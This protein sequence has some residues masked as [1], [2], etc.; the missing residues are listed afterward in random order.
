[1]VDRSMRRNMGKNNDVENVYED[2]LNFML[3]TAELNKE[4]SAFWKHIIKK[5]H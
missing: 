1:M 2:D 5:K 4:L 3:W